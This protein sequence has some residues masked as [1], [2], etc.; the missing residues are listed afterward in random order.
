MAYQ[1]TYTGYSTRSLFGAVLPSAVGLLVVLPL[2]GNPM[3]GGWHLARLLTAFLANG[4]WGIGAALIL[5]ILPS[6]LSRS[7]GRQLE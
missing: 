5:R 1:V 6:R 3:G 4:A 2:K 7:Q